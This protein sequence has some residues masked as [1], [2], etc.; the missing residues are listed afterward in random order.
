MVAI[1]TSSVGGRLRA[2]Y[3]DSPAPMP[4]RFESLLR[5]LEKGQRRTSATRDCSAV[6]SGGPRNTTARLRR[7]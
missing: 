6:K 4:E 5:E 3:D 2:L 7:G 1:V